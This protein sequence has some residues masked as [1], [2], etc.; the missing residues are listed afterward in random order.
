MSKAKI[1]KLE[2]HLVRVTLTISSEQF[3]EG[4]KYA[5]NK[6]KGQISVPGFRK[7]KVPKAMIEK[8]YGKDF[9]YEDAINFVFP[10]AYETA[11]VEN[12][13]IPVSRPTLEQPKFE[14][15]EVVLS[16]LVFEKPEITVSNYKGVEIEKVSTEAT[17]EDIMQEIKKEL[18]ANS[19]LV[20]KA[21][22]EIENGDVVKIDFEGFVDGVAFDG[23]TATDYSLEIGTKTFI[24]TFEE[25]LVGKKV[26][27]DVD[28]NV[29]FPEGYQNNNL[30]GKPALFKV[31]V[32]EINAKELPAIDDDF[33]S[34]VS[35]FDTLEEYKKD[36]FEKLTETKKQSAEAERETKV[37]NKIIEQT[38]LDIPQVM[39]ENRVSQMIEDFRSQV[40]QQGLK[41][42]EYL[43]FLG[44][45]IEG[46]RGIYTNEAK[47][48]V[49]ARL[50]LE[51]IGK[52]EK[53]EISDEEF[54]TE[55]ER[56]AT[57][58]Q[59]EPSQLKSVMRPEDRAGILEDIQTQRALKFV[60]EHSVEV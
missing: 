47:T 25:Q 36:L 39:I 55:I 58:Y 44:Q 29:T 38:E 40:E 33:A 54:D 49:Y 1:E 51:A 46:L 52:A 17:E 27:E 50:V 48:Q 43:G 60:V 28:V 20:S 9:F 19:R 22:G 32:K 11:L 14:N 57:M 23:G 31:K 53:F 26:G 30:S 12:N 16:A 13:I 56:I 41:L 24:D 18:D 42:E 10:A 3:E 15:D 34:S 59:M 7:G 2:N 8:T 45:N 6:N 5:Y 4:V 35:E 37:I 21:D